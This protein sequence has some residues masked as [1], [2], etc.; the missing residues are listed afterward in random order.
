MTIGDLETGSESLAEYL[1]SAQPCLI[2]RVDDLGTLGLQVTPYVRYFEPANEVIDEGYDPYH[3]PLGPVYWRIVNRCDEKIYCSTFLA[4]RDQVIKVWGTKGLVYCD[5]ITGMAV[6]RS[7]TILPRGECPPMKIENWSKW[8]SLSHD[9]K[10][11]QS[12]AERMRAYRRRRRRGVHCVRVQ[13]GRA[14]VNGLVAKGY[15]PSDKRQDLY[16]IQLAVNDLVF[17]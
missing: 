15:L 3:S 13:V 9:T 4:T 6:A 5:H 12:A 14:E 16:S 2:C 8:F 10:E 7:E 1:R 11:P 17:D